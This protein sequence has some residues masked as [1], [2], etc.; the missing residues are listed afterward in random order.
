[1]K[2]KVNVPKDKSLYEVLRE[3][4]LISSAYCGGRGICGKCRVKVEGR[5]ELACLVFGPFEG[6]V[7]LPEVELVSPLPTLPPVAVDGTLSGYGV[8]LDIGT[9]SLEGA[10]FELS[11]GR[12]LSAYKVVNLQ[13]SFGS[14]LISRVE[15]ARE[16]YDKLRELLLKSVSLLLSRFEVKPSF[17][18]FVSNPDIRHYFLK[19][20]VSVY[21]R[22]PFTLAC[23]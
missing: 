22:Y 10:L 7:E 8:A 6:E 18:T 12:C 13:R 5:E 17:L 1:M 21:V 3:R 2:L 23:E 14:D 16:S 11:S 19:F 4:A 20:P 9:T 15:K